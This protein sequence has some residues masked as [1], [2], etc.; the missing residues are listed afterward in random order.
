MQYVA[1]IRRRRGASTKMPETEKMPWFATL[2]NGLEMNQE[3]KH[4]KSRWL[5]KMK[6]WIQSAQKFWL[7]LTLLAGALLYI[8][9][10]CTWQDWIWSAWGVLFH[11]LSDW[12]LASCHIAWEDYHVLKWLTQNKKSEPVFLLC[13]LW[14]R[15]QSS[16]K[17]WLIHTR[18]I[19]ALRCEIL[20]RTGWSEVGTNRSQRLASHKS[21]S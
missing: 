3:A 5:K 21:R 16:S 18:F 1:S 20:V 15:P 19:Q 2:A 6:F 14:W 9:Y 7:D 8:T 11:L 10:H 13:L 4:S 17:W 12:G